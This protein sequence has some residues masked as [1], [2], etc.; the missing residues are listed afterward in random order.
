MSET[1]GER[2]N[3][4]K[5]VKFRVTEE[6]FERL[7]LMADNV[8]MTVPAFVKAKAQGTRVRQPKINREGALA[9]AKELRS[10][11]TNVNQIARWCNA[12][13]MEQLS[14]Q[15]LERLVYNLDEIKKGLA[16]AWQQLS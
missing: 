11:G 16:A 12:R 4:P 7:S 9:I 8:G 2:R 15:E 10:V 6:E 5:Q 1:K 13:D 3:E 14:E